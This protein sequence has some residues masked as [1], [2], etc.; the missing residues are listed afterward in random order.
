MKEKEKGMHFLS[1]VILTRS[2]NPTVVEPSKKKVENK[3]KY[4]NPE[5]DQSH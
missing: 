5:K 2:L 4:Q 3:R 1:L